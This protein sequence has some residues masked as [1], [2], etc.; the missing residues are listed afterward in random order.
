V[1]STGV[2]AGMLVYQLVEK[3]MMKWFHTGMAARRPTL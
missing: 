3:P 1:L 2:A